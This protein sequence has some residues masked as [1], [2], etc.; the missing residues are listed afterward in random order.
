MKYFIAIICLALSQFTLAE[1]IPAN[2]QIQKTIGDGD[3]HHYTLPLTDEHGKVTIQLTGMQDDGDLYVRQNEQPSRWWGAYDCRPYESNNQSEYCTA[4]NVGIKNT[5]HISVYGADAT[6]YTL[7]VKTENKQ[8]ET[9][10][11]LLHGI[12]SDPE[13][14][15]DVVKVL[16]QDYCPTLKGDYRDKKSLPNTRCYRYHFT[17]GPGPKGQMWEN[18]DASTYSKLGDEVGLALLSIEEIAGPQSVVLVGH[19]RGGLAARAYVQ[20]LSQAPAYGLGLLTIG[21]PHQGTPLGL[22][23][24]WMDA[25]QYD[26]SDAISDSLAFVFS[27]SADYLTAV[28]GDDG[29][30]A[31]DPRSSAIATLNSQIGALSNRI[32]IFG[33]ISSNGLELGE[34]VVGYGDVLDGAEAGKWLPGDFDDMRA[35][36]VDNLFLQQ[37]K[38]GDGI[39]PYESQLMNH[40][41]GFDRGSAELSNFKLNKVT[42]AA[43]KI[44]GE[45]REVGTIKAILDEMVK[46]DGFTPLD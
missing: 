13:T 33:Q 24:H 10:F 41:P 23:K 21:T 15:N 32:G 46:A 6:P 17:S 3:W 31:V 39:V 11:L 4:F 30:P 8:P 7:T 14:W 25:N 37:W 29:L 40:V 16:F 9:V 2:T 44:G 20:S 43:W 36:V 34:D 26:R 18:G 22:I 12:N 1:T 5:L 19:S 28:L 38:L 35:Y 45:T 27:P 42:H